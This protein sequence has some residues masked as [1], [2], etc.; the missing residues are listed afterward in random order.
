[1]SEY[2]FLHSIVQYLPPTDVKLDI[3]VTLS[4]ET[5]EIREQTV[6]E[7]V[8]RLVGLGQGETQR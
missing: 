4:P 1:M 5:S 7:V 6:D 3:Q 8:M 2:F